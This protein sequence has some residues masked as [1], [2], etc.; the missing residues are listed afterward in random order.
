MTY[1]RP[2][3]GDLMADGSDDQGWDKDVRTAE[4]KLT[5]LFHSYI[6]TGNQLAIDE[7]KIGLCADV[8][9]MV[10]H[11]RDHHPQGNQFETLEKNI[12]TY[13]GQEK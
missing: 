1:R 7:A 12:N 2:D 11:I 4:G 5:T 10:H 9:A 8:L 3:E 6:P 13:F